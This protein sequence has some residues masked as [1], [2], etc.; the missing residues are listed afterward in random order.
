MPFQSMRTLPRSVGDLLRR[1]GHD[2]TDV[3][4]LGCRAPPTRRW[5]SMHNEKDCTCFYLT[6]FLE[7]LLQND[8]VEQ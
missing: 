1:Y 7:G 6:Q 3:R 5:L 4:D 8:L 2:A